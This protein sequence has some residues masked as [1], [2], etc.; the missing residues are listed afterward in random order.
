MEAA[1]Q[2]EAAAVGVEASQPEGAAAGVGA[3]ASVGAVASVDA[4]VGVG[5]SQLEGKRNRRIAL[6]L[7]SYPEGGMDR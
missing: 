3:A 7:P 2:A 5:A 4:A 1:S 6:S